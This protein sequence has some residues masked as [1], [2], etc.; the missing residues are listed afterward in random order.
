M[1]EE[2]EINKIAEKLTNLLPSFTRKFMRPFELQ[3]KNVTSLLHVALLH[4][5]REKELSTLTELSI[6]MNMS[7]QQMTPIINKLHENG[8]ILREQDNLDRRSVNLKLTSVGI[9]FL[10]NIRK[11]INRTMAKKIY[12]LDKNDLHTLD[13]ALDDLFKIIN[14]I[15]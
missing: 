13:H 15:S 10:E 7:K 2:E 4:N 14:K 11:D 1:L 3:I 5:L 6:T 8:F 12:C 9:D